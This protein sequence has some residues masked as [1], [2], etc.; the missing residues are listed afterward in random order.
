MP[1][2]AFRNHHQQIDKDEHVGDQKADA[3]ER[4]AAKDL[5]NLERQEGCGDDSRKVLA[6]SLLKIKADALEDPNA[7]VAESGEADTAQHGI[8]EQGGAVEKE[9]N[10]AAF[11]V[12]AEI[13]GDLGQNITDVF[14]HKL[15]RAHA[16]SD[17]E[18]G[19]EQLVNRDQDESSV[20][21]SLFLRDLQRGP[22]HVLPGPVRPGSTSSSYVNG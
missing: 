9:I 3:R 4:E 10:D 14:A 19:L 8:V 7:G 20:V 1:T 11:R 18:E 5:V 13:A 15:H 12:E 17:E 22:R 21:L 6:P 2:L 16:Q